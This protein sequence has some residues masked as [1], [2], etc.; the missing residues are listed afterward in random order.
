MEQYITGQ[1]FLDR[2][3][4]AGAIVI[5]DHDGR[6]EIVVGH[7]SYSVGEHDIDVYAS[8]NRI[9][10]DRSEGNYWRFCFTPDQ[11]LEFNDFFQVRLPCFTS[12]RTFHCNVALLQ[13]MPPIP[14]TPSVMI[15]V[16]GGIIQNVT[17][18][19]DIKIVTV[20]FDDEDQEDPV[21]VTD[22]TSDTDVITGTF[23]DHI[24]QSL[25]DMPDETQS[26]TI[27]ELRSLGF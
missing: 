22:W 24:G 18:T 15:T 1:Q 2:L 10:T 20:S 27:T 8:L 23:S 21:M 4:A 3:E 9:Y 12:N 17:T 5:Y 14:V 6:K 11:H 13:Y 25:T 16:E 7:P 19:A 26:L